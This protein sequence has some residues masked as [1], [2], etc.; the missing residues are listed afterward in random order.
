MAIHVHALQRLDMLRRNRRPISANVLEDRNSLH[1]S[2]FSS[3][4]T[5]LKDL[6]LYSRL[7]HA[8]L[9]SHKNESHILERLYYKSKNQHRSALFWRHVCEMRRFAKRLEEFNV[10]VV[11]DSLRA[12]FFRGADPAK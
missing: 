3:I 1:A 10:V 6:K 9:S 11:L 5:V 4:D 7:L 8:I 2:K 12:T